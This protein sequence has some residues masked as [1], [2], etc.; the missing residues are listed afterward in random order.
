MHEQCGLAHY[1]IKL[2]NIV[3]NEHFR[4]KLIDFA[5]ADPKDAVQW[6]SRGT[7]SYKAPEVELA[8]ENE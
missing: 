8:R 7:E 2:E 6:Q 4:L 1:D 3:V 5:Y